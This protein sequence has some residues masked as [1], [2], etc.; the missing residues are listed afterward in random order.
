MSNNTGVEKNEQLLNVDY[1]FDHQMSLGKSKCWYSNNEET[2][3]QLFLGTAENCQLF[4]FY[5]KIC[6]NT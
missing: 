2:N 5:N 1:N 4:L 6:H 3:L